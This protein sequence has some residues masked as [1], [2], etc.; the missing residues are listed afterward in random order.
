MS[1]TPGPW[2]IADHRVYE[3]GD[4]YEIEQKHEPGDYRG[5]VCYIQSCDH[6]QG[7][8]RAEAEANA[9]LI[10]LAPEMFELLKHLH[11]F[12]DDIYSVRAMGIMARVVAP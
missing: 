11:E 5:P 3:E 1:H 9:R 10:T 7:I 8:T 2:I 6:I 4:V 12:P